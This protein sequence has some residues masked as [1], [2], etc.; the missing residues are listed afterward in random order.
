[1]RIFALFL[2]PQV[3]STSNRGVIG[4]G[5]SAENILSY[6]HAKRVWSHCLWKPHGVSQYIKLVGRGKQLEV[7]PSRVWGK[8][9][10]NSV[11]EAE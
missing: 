8:E 10:T 6:K 5:M 9:Y 4:L 2:A 3:Y 11:A 1:M 7:I